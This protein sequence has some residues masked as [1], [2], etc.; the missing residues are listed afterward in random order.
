MYTARGKG[1]ISSIHNS[2]SHISYDIMKLILGQVRMMCHQFDQLSSYLA[3]VDPPT[4]ASE[5]NS[6]QNSTS[7][8]RA[9]DSDLPLFANGAHKDVAPESKSD[10]VAPESKSDE[11]APDSKSDDVAPESKSDETIQMETLVNQDGEMEKSVPADDRNGVAVERSS[12]EESKME[13]SSPKALSFLTSVT[14]ALFESALTQH[15]IM[16]RVSWMLKPIR[17]LASALGG[18]ALLPQNSEPELP[19]LSMASESSRVEHTK[20]QPSSNTPFVLR[21]SPY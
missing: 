19:S 16:G 17:E 20:V 8:N 18:L 12:N 9:M 1:D 3:Q 11:V 13:E 4:G 10:E 5:E 14:M 7:L 6:L 15:D 21:Q 2:R